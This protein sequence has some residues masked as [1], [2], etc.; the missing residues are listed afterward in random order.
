MLFD[1]L[2]AKFART[3]AASYIPF[4]RY[5]EEK[6]RR[7]LKPLVTNTQFIKCIIW[8]MGFGLLTMYAMSCLEDFLRN[9]RFGG[10]LLTHT[11]RQTQTM[12]EW[13]SQWTKDE[14]RRWRNR[15]DLPICEKRSARNE[16]GV[17][18]SRFDHSECQIPFLDCT[19]LLQTEPRE[20]KRQGTA[21]VFSFAVF[22]GTKFF[23]CQL[24]PNVSQSVSVGKRF[25]VCSN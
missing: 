12:H 1:V 3:C 8:L 20:R 25:A 13:V 15:S 7:E 18:V 6:C 5:A 24:Q 4:T 2:L 23:A 16:F 22:F 19:F 9:Q 21:A 14:E 17:R 10:Q 11:I